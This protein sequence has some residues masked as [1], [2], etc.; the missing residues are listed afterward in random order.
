MLQITK[1]VH[2]S[3]ITC[4]SN[5]IMLRSTLVW[6]APPV[7]L[8]FQGVTSSFSSH[9]VP[10]TRNLFVTKWVHIKHY[11]L[12]VDPAPDDFPRLFHFQKILNF[13]KW[14]PKIQGVLFLRKKGPC[15]ETPGCRPNGFLPKIVDFLFW[16]KRSTQPQR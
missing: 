15:Q 9:L 11:G 14:V 10:G 5:L 1:I 7:T 16:M 4:Y 6:P 13:H 3:Q 2:C 12:L 8:A